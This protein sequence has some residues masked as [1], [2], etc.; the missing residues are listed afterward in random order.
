MRK[1]IAGL[2]ISLDGVVEA[3]QKWHFPYLDEEMAQSVR[4]LM[5]RGDALLLGRGT[6]DEF[7]AH[8][9]HQDPA[10]PM[11]RTLNE[12]PKYVVSTTLETATWQNS[13]IVD[14]DVA[15]RLTE[16]KQRPGKDIVMSG[17]PTLVSWLLT[18]GLLDEL[19]LLVHPIILGTGQ[20]LFTEG[21]G[22]IPLTL[23]TSESYSTG[24]LDLTYERA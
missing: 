6:Y 8:W 21:I 15:A 22:Q 10:D 11:A 18:E 1:I 4:W 24:V 17:S 19:H 5:E 9:P 23:T 16:L 12:I 3:P 14:G 13:T 7:A 2:F 20:R